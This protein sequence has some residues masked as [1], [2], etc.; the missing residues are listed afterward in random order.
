MCHSISLRRCSRRKSVWA[1]SPPS[2]LNPSSLVSLMFLSLRHFC[3]FN[4]L[5]FEIVLWF[6]FINAACGIQADMSPFSFTA[7]TTW[8]TTTER[9]ICPFGWYNSGRENTG[10]I[11]NPDT[12]QARWGLSYWPCSVFSVWACLWML[13][14]WMDREHRK[15]SEEKSCSKE[16][17]EVGCGTSFS[18]KRSTQAAT[19]STLAR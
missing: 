3:L 12:L 14:N 16:W 10:D 5:L 2:P 11:C 4:M 7:S 9:I 17:D 13:W 8:R 6:F 15:H 1:L 19:T 18:C